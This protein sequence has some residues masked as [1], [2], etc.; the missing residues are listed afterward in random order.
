MNRKRHEINRAI[1]QVAEEVIRILEKERPDADAAHLKQLRVSAP[2]I[3]SYF[4]RTAANFDVFSDLSTVRSRLLQLWERRKKRRMRFILDS[5][6]FTT[7]EASI[8]TQRRKKRQRTM[9][10]NTEPV[11]LP[12]LVPKSTSEMPWIPPAA[13]SSDYYRICCE[14]AE[15]NVRLQRMLESSNHKST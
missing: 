6:N 7:P 15:E 10:E 11:A 14:L 4:H 8:G 2:R 1:E 13:V 5:P 12:M 3:A 9:S